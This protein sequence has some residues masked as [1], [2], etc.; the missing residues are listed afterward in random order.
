M[1][2]HAA[3]TLAVF[4]DNI[5]SRCNCGST[6]ASWWAS[7]DG[8]YHFYL[9]YVQTLEYILSDEKHVTAKV[10][11][12]NYRFSLQPKKQ[13]VYCQLL[14]NF[15]R[16]EPHRLKHYTFTS[17]ATMKCLLNILIVNSCGF[18]FLQLTFVSIHPSIHPKGN[19]AFR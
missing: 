13:S 6:A 4:D 19:A 15:P 5:Q 2:Q 12:E 8:L 14:I 9:Q 11:A 7:P 10:K 3:I 18:H 16:Q 1:E 17:A